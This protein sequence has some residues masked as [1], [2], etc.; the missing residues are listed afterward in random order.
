MHGYALDNRALH[1]KTLS[2]SAAGPVEFHED[3]LA[4]AGGLS[5]S[6]VSPS[7]IAEFGEAIELVRKVGLVG[8][9]RN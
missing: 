2:T 7:F 5:V 3:V 8:V 9:R 1:D 6:H 4:A